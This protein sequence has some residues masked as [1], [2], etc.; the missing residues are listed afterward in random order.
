MGLCVCFLF[1][2]ECAIEVEININY[3]VGGLQ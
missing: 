2:M 3:V 1:Y